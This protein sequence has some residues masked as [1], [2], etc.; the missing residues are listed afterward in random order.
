MGVFLTAWNDRKL[1]IMHI[2]SDYEVEK[3]K[4]AVE[5]L[6][7][8]NEEKVGRPSWTNE[9]MLLYELFISKICPMKTGR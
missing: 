2:F 4:Q 7:A 1:V 6:M 8:T 5:S 9:I 3:L